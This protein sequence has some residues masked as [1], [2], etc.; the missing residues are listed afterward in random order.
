MG[1]R[2]RA[3]GVKD[4]IEHIKLLKETLKQVTEELE[5]TCTHANIDAKEYSH[6]DEWERRWWSDYHIKCK[7]CGKYFCKITEDCGK[8]SIKGGMV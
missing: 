1:K 2:R 7:D 3:P 6:E 4:K 5:K 8:F